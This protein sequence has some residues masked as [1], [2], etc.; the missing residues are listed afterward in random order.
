MA[1]AE[2]VPIERYTGDGQQTEFPVGWRFNHPAHLQLL[3]S[4]GRVLILGRDYQVVDQQVVFN[5]PP[6]EGEVIA[7]LR[8]T[9]KERSGDYDETGSIPGSSLNFNYDAA[10]LMIQELA[11]E[12]SRC[13]KASATNPGITDQDELLKI[14]A[15]LLEEIQSVRESLLAMRDEIVKELEDG[16]E[17]I[18]GII[19]SALAR[20][21]ALLES[22]GSLEDLIE[23]V[24]NLDIDCLMP[25]VSSIT[26]ENS[27]N[28]VVARYPM[29]SMD[30]AHRVVLEFND[31]SNLFFNNGPALVYGGTGGNFLDLGWA[32]SAGC[33]K[34]TQ[35]SEAIEFKIDEASFGT[36]NYSDT[37][38]AEDYLTI[39]FRCRFNEVLPSDRRRALVELWSENC[40]DYWSRDLYGRLLLT[41]AWNSPGLLQ[42]EMWNNNGS[43]GVIWA[44]ARLTGLFDGAWHLIEWRVRP[45]DRFGS[46]TLPGQ[47]LW[48][49]GEFL[50]PTFYSYPR[51]RISSYGDLRISLGKG[52]HREAEAASSNSHDGRTPLATFEGWC[53]GRF[54]ELVI[55]T[56]R[57]HENEE[58]YVPDSGPLVGGG[59]GY[60]ISDRPL[61]AFPVKVTGESDTKKLTCAVTNLTEDENNAGQWNLSGQPYTAYYHM[62]EATPNNV[63][64]MYPPY[65][66]LG[67]GSEDCSLNAWRV[68][69]PTVPYDVESLLYNQPDSV[70]T[71]YEVCNGSVWSHTK[72]QTGYRWNTRWGVSVSSSVYYKALKQNWGHPPLRIE[73]VLEDDSI[74][75]AL[76]TGAT[77]HGASYGKYLRG[78]RFEGQDY[79]FIP[80]LTAGSITDKSGMLSLWFRPKTDGPDTQSQ[81]LYFERNMGD[82][83]LV[84]LVGSKISVYLLDNGIESTFSM[85]S[86]GSLFNGSYHHFLLMLDKLHKRCRLALDGVIQYSNFEFGFPGVEGLNSEYIYWDT[87][88]YGGMIHNYS[89]FGAMPQDGHWGQD[90][91]NQK[92]Y[93]MINFYQGDLDE[94][95]SWADPDINTDE[96]FERVADWLW[97]SGNGLFYP[98]SVGE[99]AQSYVPSVGDM[100]VVLGG[101]F[102]P[103]AVTLA[104]AITG[105]VEQPDTEN[106]DQTTDDP[107]ES[108]I[109]EDP[110]NT[111]KG[112]EVIDAWA[113]DIQYVCH[114][115]E[116]PL[117][118]SCTHAVV[119][120]GSD[121]FP[122][123]GQKK[124]LHTILLNELKLLY[125]EGEGRSR[126]WCGTGTVE[127]TD[128]VYNPDTGEFEQRTEKFEVIKAVL[129]WNTDA[130]KWYLT[131]N[132]TE[133][134]QYMEPVE[135]K[136]HTDDEGN[137][138]DY[139]VVERPTVCR[140]TMQLYA[141]YP[142]S[143]EWT[144]M[145]FDTPDALEHV[146]VKGDVTTFM[147]EKEEKE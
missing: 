88:S 94:F 90:E 50:P 96:D 21:D 145:R 51:W 95:V 64:A 11:E 14:F 17:G 10:I 8:D 62:R 135:L 110:Y 80:Q 109:E 111:D 115:E 104:N 74:N 42:I 143:K 32:R 123:I 56:I 119:M 139:E 99:M 140:G 144:G 127:K 6:A 19:N 29:G 131:I 107:V 33:L 112:T 125:T 134:E 91:S 85:E 108:P 103:T 120:T 63:F 20:I 92:R 53:P 27:G 1:V 47:A 87:Y 105:A 13:V 82:I 84:S 68:V 106:P 16:A 22:I 77:R 15:Q 34:I 58:N 23:R 28:P 65:C 72:G 44:N 73:A 75:T 147:V 121:G 142:V 133:I 54:D 60:V 89:V 18:A 67:F 122:Y 97:N 117:N 116:L 86:S 132:Q 38:N 24:E 69:T 46:T 137:L 136:I 55:S 129:S 118:Y 76:I 41:M 37:V 57:R 40:V 25:P 49:D 124:T 78:W 146:F 130:S 102:L 31:S 7:I 3:S 9:P 52:Y 83:L 4:T 36:M 5:E 128:T 59:A 70:S 12:L 30:S 114:G 126:V 26:P 43:P 39:S 98:G 35:E 141:D 81:T 138:I 79:L 48:L 61:G 101:I 113:G 71:E 66:V 2:I 45:G 93:P 100:G